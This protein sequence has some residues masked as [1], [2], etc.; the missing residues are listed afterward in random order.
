MNKSRSSDDLRQIFIGRPTV[1]IIPVNVI[2]AR[3]FYLI[4]LYR[5]NLELIKFFWT[6]S[7]FDCSSFM[8]V[9]QIIDASLPFFNSL[10][11]NFKSYRFKNTVGTNQ[12]CYQ[13]RIQSP[14]TMF[15]ITMAYL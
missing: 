13:R 6:F 15:N 7:F 14:D 12:G 5:F 9:N 3:Y 8:L 4:K 1:A 2:P 11:Y 10:L